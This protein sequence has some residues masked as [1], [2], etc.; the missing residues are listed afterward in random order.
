MAAKTFTFFSLILILSLTAKSQERKLSISDPVLI[1]ES[2][3]LYSAEDVFLAGQPTQTNLDSLIDAGVTL[4]INLRTDDEMDHLNFDEAKYLK[5]KKIKYLHIAMGGDAGYQAE[6]IDKMGK[7]INK[8]DGKV[9]I[10]CRSA[11]RATYA[12]MAW[13]IRYQDYSIDEAV[14]MGSKARFSVPFFSLLGYPVTI[15]KK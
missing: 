4:V 13:L 8:T 3:N 6:A 7:S 15:Q 10:H 2:Y 1:D 12:W 11:G 14:R 5:S 9:L